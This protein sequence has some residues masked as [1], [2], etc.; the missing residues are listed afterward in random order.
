[1]CKN[2][3][4]LSQ[5]DLTL[6]QDTYDGLLQII[7]A[8]NR[9]RCTRFRLKKDALCTLYGELMLRNVLIQRFS[10]KNEDIEILRRDDGKPYVKGL[11]IHFNISHSGEF[12]VCA[13]SEQEVGIDIERIKEVDLNIARRFFCKSEYEDLLAQIA[14]KQL[15]YFFSIWTLKESYM[16]W[17][18]SGMEIPLDSFCFKASDSS[19]CL[20]DINRG[21]KPFFKQ[22]SFEGYRISICSTI[23]NFST[24]IEKVSVDEMKF[25]Y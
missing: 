23:E 19:I 5:I 18:G 11:P 3:I 24:E 9:E 1:M 12:V 21:V 15:D 13:V 10:L 17:L 14:D 20:T 22:I 16:K 2:R 8:Q 6:S 7:S 25:G 4:Y